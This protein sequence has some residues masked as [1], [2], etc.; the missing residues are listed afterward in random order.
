MNTYAICNSPLLIN[1]ASQLL[2]LIEFA[3]KSPL[4][5]VNRSPIRYG[6]LSGT[7]A[8]RYSVNIA[9]NSELI[10]RPLVNA[11]APEPFV[12]ARADPHPFYRL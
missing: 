9:L 12:T 11:F 6:S 8:L 2:S 3:P 10:G 5:C 7:K 1:G 4:L